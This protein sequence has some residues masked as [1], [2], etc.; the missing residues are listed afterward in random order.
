MEPSKIT[1][2]PI[3]TTL[4]Y[5]WVAAA[6]YINLTVLSARPTTQCADWV[7]IPSS[8]TRGHLRNVNHVHLPYA[9][10]RR[11]EIQWEQYTCWKLNVLETTSTTTKID[12]E[13]DDDDDDDDD[14]EDF[15][16]DE[17]DCY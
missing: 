14:D 8:N 3:W 2:A 13:N 6:C 10:A 4:P 15:D 17:Y 12:D 5:L 16:N 7:I 1:F 9:V 11:G